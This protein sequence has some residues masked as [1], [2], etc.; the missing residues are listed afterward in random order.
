MARTSTPSTPATPAPASSGIQTAGSSSVK[1]DVNTAKA[2]D[3]RF[4]L[5]YANGPNPFAGPEEAHADRQ[6]REPHD[7]AALDR[8]VEDVGLL[9]RHG[10]AQRRREHDRV[11]VRG[12][13]RR[14]RQPRLA[15]ARPGGH[16]A[17]RGRVGHARRHRQGA[18]RARGLQ[19]PGLRRRL[20]DRGRRHHAAGQRARRRR[21]GRHLGLRERPEPVHRHQAPEPLR[22]RR[23]PEEGLLPG[24]G[25]V[26]ELPDAERQDHRQ[27]RQQRHPAQV[28]HGRRGQRQRRLPGLQAERTDQLRHRRRERHVRRHHAGQVPLDD[29]PQRGRGRLL[30]HRR[31]AADQGGRAETSPAPM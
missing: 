5:H 7:H 23:L 12:E 17:L 16:D 10:R 24:H 1:V 22:Q 18:D 31:Q 27:G 8:H 3:Y 30:A 28:R 11:Q 13:R 26:A 6:R 15:A 14:Q 25:R 2:G 21:G 19:R 9:P 4:T 20:R 29:G